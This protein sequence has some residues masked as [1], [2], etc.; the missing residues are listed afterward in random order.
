MSDASRADKDETAALY[1]RVA[2][3]FGGDYPIFERAGQRMAAL[4]GITAGERVLD[5]ACG[6]GASL[7]SAAAR[8]GAGGVAVGLDLAAAMVRE[9]AR[10]ARARG[11]ANVALLRG[12]AETIPFRDAAFDAVLCGF[13]IFF[14][15]A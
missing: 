11:L 12:D 15:D 2:P 4:A 10:E 6:R 7:L 9:T 3:T 8:V 14:L 13:A 1:D 5:V